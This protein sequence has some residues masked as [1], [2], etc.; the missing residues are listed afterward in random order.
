MSYDK[1]ELLDDSDFRPNEYGDM[2]ETLDDEL[3]NESTEED[4]FRFNNEEEPENI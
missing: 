2:N 1:D 3:F 4:G